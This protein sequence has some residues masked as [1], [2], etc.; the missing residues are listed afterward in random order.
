MGA[1]R[2][3]LVREGR[4]EVRRRAMKTTIIWTGA[5][6]LASA[7]IA[8]ADDG[9]DIAMVRVRLSTE[10]VVAKGC[11]RIGNVSDDS[12]KDL[13]KKIVRS[14]GDTGILTFSTDDMEMILAAV[15]RC[16]TLRSTT[17]KIT[18]PPPVPPP[19]PRPAR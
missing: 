6:L 4:R 5:L 3:V 9:E 19:P 7:S 10:S 16:P 15:Y 2:G 14:G 8:T 13:R 18:P 1:T 17:P 12:V 11:T